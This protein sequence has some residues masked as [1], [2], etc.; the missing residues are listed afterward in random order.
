MIFTGLIG[1]PINYTLSPKIHNAAFKCLGLRGIYLPLP[2]KREN[3]T[4]FMKSLKNKNFRGLNVTIPYKERVLGCLDRLAPEAECI[5]AVNTLLI[6]KGRISGHNTDL[7]GFRK[8]LTENGVKIDGRK[9]L[10]IGGGGAGRAC[11]CVIQDMKP[12]AFFVADLDPGR[13]SSTAE[14][15]GAESVP[16]A[17]LESVLAKNPDLVVN[18]TPAD[19][20]ENV[21]PV[22]KPG[23][24]YYDLNYRFGMNSKRG[25]KVMNGLSMLVWQ[26][27]QS[28]ALW[29]GR[30]APIRAMRAAAG[31]I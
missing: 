12:R 30:D 14:K 21:L 2:I 4:S 26:A 3:L 25:V 6:E 17:R 24:A 9:V 19:L 8:S 23:A 18:A 20:Q 11:A 7:A 5:G 13:A 16:F 10:L 27:A 22:L 1:Y 28:F 31:L 15:F 29:T